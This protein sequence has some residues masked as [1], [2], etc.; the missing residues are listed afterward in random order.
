MAPTGA[1]LLKSIERYMIT[2]FAERP[3][4]PEHSSYTL[5]SP[6]QAKISKKPK[7][8]LIHTH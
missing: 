5:G 7:A 4:S 3:K 1:L 6:H 8:V 2:K